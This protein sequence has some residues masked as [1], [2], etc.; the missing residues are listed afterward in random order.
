[1]DSHKMFLLERRR[2]LEEELVIS[3]PD[4]IEYE[5]LYH[6]WQQVNTELAFYRE[7]DSD[8]QPLDF[9]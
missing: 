9:N 6:E 3:V 4:T 7:S 5:N 1:M 2:E 8:Y